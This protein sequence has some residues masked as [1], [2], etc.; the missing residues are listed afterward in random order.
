MEES[1]RGR[2]SGGLAHEDAGRVVLGQAL[3]PA[4]EVHGVP[5]DRVGPAILRAQSPRHRAS[6]VEADAYL[7]GRDKGLPPWQVGI[8]LNTGR[9]V[10]GTLGSENRWSYT[11]IGDSV[12]LASRLEGLTKHYAARILVSQSTR[13]A[14]AGGF[15]HR[16]MDLVRVKGKQEA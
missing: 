8:G 6:G 5:D 4:G 16:P 14:A 7:P 1:P 13:Q 11:V 9:A 10:A 15:L 12:N 2:L 3:E